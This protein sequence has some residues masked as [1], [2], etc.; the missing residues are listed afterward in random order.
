MNENCTS[1]DQET[2][3]R[4]CDVLYGILDDFDRICTENGLRYYLGYGSALGAVRHGGFIPWD[5]DIDVCMPREDYDR[6]LSYCRDHP[7]DMYE[8]INIRIDPKYISAVTKYQKK[9]TVFVGYHSR[10]IQCELG[11]AID[12]FPLDGI[13]DDDSRVLRQMR[14]ATF[15]RRLLF[16]RSSPD[17]VITGSGI[18]KSCEKLLCRLIHYSLRLLHISPEW[19]YNRFDSISVSGNDSYSERL[20]VFHGDPIIRK[21]WR[22]AD[23]FPSER[24]TLSNGKSY[25]VPKNAHSYL[26]SCYGERYMELPPEEQRINHRPIKLDFGE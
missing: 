22:Y 5:D 2:L 13:P 21:C 3:H 23:L 1:Y 9:G 15:W 25:C 24:L 12:I 7:S 19:L 10:N 8:V 11:I 26:V 16:L 6:F 4:L 17:P 14:K 18:K 20:T